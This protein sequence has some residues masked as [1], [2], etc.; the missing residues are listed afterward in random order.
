[1]PKSLAFCLVWFAWS[2][3]LTTAV[4]QP[5]PERPVR[6]LV[7]FAAGGSVDTTGRVLAQSLSGRWG[8]PIVV[9]N[10]AGAVGLI[11]MQ[12]AE[13]APNDGYTLMMGSASQFTV[14]PALEGGQSSYPPLSRFT[15]I[16][17]LVVAP[18][19]LTVHPSLPVHSFKELMH[20][21][22]SRPGPI[23]Y[24]STGV[25]TPNHIAMALIGR[26]GGFEVVHVP[27]KG[28]G[29]VVVA[30]V[31]GQVPLA[32]GSF[33]TAVPH[34]KSGRLRA[35]G[36]T[37]SR[38]LSMAP[39]VPTIAESGLPGFEVSQWYG[40]FAPAGLPPVLTKKIGADVAAIVVMPDV[41]GRFEG[42]GL[43]VS[44]AASAEFGAY[45]K[46]ELIKWTKLVKELG[47]E[48]KAK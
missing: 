27:Y 30:A 5:Y 24:G 40:L 39:D 41:R 36:V 6:L 34:I 42:Q 1:M 8:R 12:I 31:S 14:G 23:S 22:K 4:A 26:S 46:A 43:D 45:I 48:T 25:G 9:E 15:P 10:R 11:A 13:K 19:V 17:K 21:A 20:Y 2:V 18:I 7:G 29:D 44:Y 28:G 35:L 33:S 37:E 47:L 32:M 16:A 38:R 3:A